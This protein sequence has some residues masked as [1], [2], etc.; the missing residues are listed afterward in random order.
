MSRVAA[1]G[2]SLEYE[3]FGDPAHPA[4]LLIIGF[5][6][7]MT[8]WPVDLC[9]GLAA[10]GFRVVRFDNRDTGLSQKFDAYGVP[11]L[12]AASAAAAAGKHVEASYTEDDMADDA[13]GLLRVLGIERAVVGGMS[14]GGRIAQ[15]MALRHPELI[16]G[17]AI[18]MSTSGAPGLPAGDERVRQVLFEAPEDPT[19]RDCIIDLGLRI[20]Q[21]IRSPGFDADLEDFRRKLN[22]DLDRTMYL[23]GYA[24]N[25]LAMIAAPPFHEDLDDISA[26]TLVLHGSDDLV[27]PAAAGADIAARIPGA[28]LRVVEGWGHEVFSPGVAPVLID[29]IST[30]FK[31]KP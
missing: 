18:M 6:L 9:R 11:D 30:H 21:A 7:Q 13:A 14:M 1:N 12:V 29:A 22:A 10:K 3:E 5:G 26:P 19:D 16:S 4:L 27:I 15:R 17:L 24:R 23:E 25:L 31:D 28:E 2:V 8:G 20:F